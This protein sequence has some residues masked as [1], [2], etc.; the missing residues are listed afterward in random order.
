MSTNYRNISQTLRVG[1][2]N[3]PTSFLRESQQ[4]IRDTNFNTNLYGISNDRI[5][6][7]PEFYGY[8]PNSPLTISQQYSYEEVTKF[9]NAN[10]LQDALNSFDDIIQKIDFGGNLDKSKLKFTSIPQG[11][12]NFGL[13]SKGLFRPVEYYSTEHKKV[14]D[15]N[16]VRNTELNGQ[17]SFFFEDENGNDSPLRIQQ[18]GTYLVEKNCDGVIVVYD[19]DAQMFLPYKNN[20]PFVGCGKIDPIAN[21]P[22]RLRFATTTKKVY[23]YRDKLGGGMSPYVDLF[24]V[25]G[26]LGDMTTESMLVKNLPLMIVSKFLNDA[27][28]KTRIY[29]KR[30]YKVYGAGDMQYVDYSFVVK[31]YGESLDFNQIAAFTSDVRF[32]RVNL[33]NSVPAL[34]NKKDNLLVTGY[35]TTLYGRISPSNSDELVP[36]FNMSRNYAINGGDSTVQSTKVNDP[37]LMIIGGI[38]NISG[39]DTISNPQSIE[40]VTNEIYRIG[41]YV[42][43]MFSKNVKKTLNT[44][45]QR[46]LERQAN[47]SNKM[48]YIRDYLRQTILDNLVTIRPSQVVNP[49][50]ATPSS[51]VKDIDDQSD[52]LLKA[53]QDLIN[54]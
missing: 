31:D 11:V 37:R 25:I 40:K 13:A 50:F 35:G 46:E 42:S 52:E 24:L 29:A 20:K 22:S 34:L 7:D 6:V 16:M 36:V 18:E 45:Y 27:G 5:R 54:P 1:F 3:S 32:F 41:D 38:G 12:F 44:I 49:D 33:W 17:I 2:W 10:L 26:G 43:L 21:K 8:N 23:M 28:I 51:M 30:A 9:S 47:M 48:S 19:N 4:Y 39:S 15:A 14:V 53:L